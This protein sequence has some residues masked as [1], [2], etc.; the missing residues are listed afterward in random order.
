MSTDY[1]LASRQGL[2]L[3]NRKGHR[4]L[5]TGRF[6][7][8]VV[9]E[10]EV[11]AFLNTAADAGQ[12]SESSGAIVAYAWDGEG[13]SNQRV[14]VEG[15][16]HNCHQV[17]FFDGSFFVVDTFHQCIREYDA[18]WRPIAAHRI[19]PEAARNGPDHGHI[20]SIAGDGKTVRV[21]LHNLKRK[22]LSE[23]FEY[24]RQ[25]RERG[26]TTLPG[27][28]CHDIVPLEDGRLLTCL[29]DDGRIAIVGGEAFQIDEY[30]TRG[31]VVG[32]DEIAVGSSLYGRRVARAILPGFVTF[33]DRGFA[34][35]GRIYVPAAPTQ[36][37]AL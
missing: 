21:L 13:L 35:T 22:Q 18:D 33:L 20:N 26:R 2:F 25:F 12:D 9:R 8:V 36:M 15:L 27:S 14:L 28:G 23:I 34:Q 30:W 24:D 10:G 4:P 5:T 32:P 3:V 7:G 37:R 19:L 1:L 16:D 17:D 6:F 31:L 29:S 11:F